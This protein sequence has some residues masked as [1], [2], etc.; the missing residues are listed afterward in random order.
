MM[1]DKNYRKI[2]LVILIFLVGAT[3][4]YRGSYFVTYYPYIFLTAVLLILSFVKDRKLQGL[5]FVFTLSAMAAI[6]FWYY[7]VFPTYDNYAPITAPVMTIYQM[8]GKF[9]V[10]YSPD[11]PQQGEAITSYINI[12]DNDL[13]N[14][15][16]LNNYTITAYF[17][18]ESKTKHLLIDNQVIEDNFELK[19]FGK[20]IHLRFGY[21]NK[22]YLQEF[23]IP[24]P[25]FLQSIVSNIPR[26]PITFI[27][28]IVSIIIGLFAVKEIY[29]Y[30]SKKR[31]I[32]NF[33][34][35][36]KSFLKQRKKVNPSNK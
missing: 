6:L 4:F 19:Y 17:I 28:N 24:K 14:C 36:L 13:K 9:Q 2:L 12:C 34:S 5:I 33:L 3:L 29:V 23:N 8:F 25:S 35:T 10:F 31:Y 20:P 11:Y 30:L 18:D 26:H 27:F 22:T 21:K 15:S 7:G 32:S 16:Q 1:V